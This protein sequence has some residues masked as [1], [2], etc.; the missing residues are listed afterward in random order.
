MVNFF[1]AYSNLSDHCMKDYKACLIYSDGTHAIHL[2]N[3]RKE[4]YMGH[5]QFL[6]N[7]HPY[8]RY[9]KSFNGEQKWDSAPKS[10]SGEEIYE[11]VSQVITQFGKKA[12]S[13]V[14]VRK[15]EKRK[16]KGNS[17]GVKIESRVRIEVD[18]NN[19]EKKKEEESLE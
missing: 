14:E 8:R 13:N 2:T 10:L 4:V 5:R 7:D 19:D 15:I 12:R 18:T 17:K 6:D 11:K 1:L 9:I 3:C 16:E